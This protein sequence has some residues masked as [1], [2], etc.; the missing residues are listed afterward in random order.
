MGQG[1]LPPPPSPLRLLACCVVPPGGGRL[2]AAGSGLWRGKFQPGHR[3]A[4]VVDCLSPWG[5]AENRSEIA[6]TQSPPWSAR[7]PAA[8]LGHS[9]AL[10]PSPALPSWEMPD[11]PSV[12]NGVCVGFHL[13]I[14]FN[15]VSSCGVES[16][17]PTLG[18]APGYFLVRGGLHCRLPHHHRR[19][20]PLP[21]VALR[22]RA[23]PSRAGEKP[24]SPLEKRLCTA[25]CAAGR[26]SYAVPA[27][28]SR[29]S[30]L[31]LPSVGVN[32]P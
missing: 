22:A 5:G 7:V 31:L 8:V 28:L 1:T 23:E 26:P 19:R 10:L 21:G 32:Y 29:C 15:I 16:C 18:I 17:W 24:I 2:V 12:W 30:Q 20:P 27:L 4:A 25:V 3:V 14:Y 9:E 6:S 13:F 11:S